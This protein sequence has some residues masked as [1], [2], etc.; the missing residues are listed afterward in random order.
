MQISSAYMKKGPFFCKKNLF[1]QISKFFL[2][3]LDF[4]C[5]AC[6]RMASPFE[7]TGETLMFA[8]KYI[9]PV[10]VL[11]GAAFCADAHP[12][13]H[14][15]GVHLAAEIVGLVRSVIAPKPVVVTPPPPPVV[16]TPAPVVVAPPPPPVVVTPAPVVVTPAPVVVTP[17]P[18]VVA[19]PPPPRPVYHHRPAPPPRPVYHHRPAP[20]HPGRHHPAQHR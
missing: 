5:A 11:L 7:T 2:L 15:E 4:L 6:Y 8:S 18:V 10:T 14:N 20:R 17:P 19:P 9:I 16:V 3:R 13:H 1:R 12:R